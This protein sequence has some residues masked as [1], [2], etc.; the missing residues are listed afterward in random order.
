MDPACCFP[1]IGAYLRGGT[2]KQIH[3]TCWRGDLRSNT[4]DAAAGRKSH[5][6]T[7]FLHKGFDVLTGGLALVA[8]VLCHVKADTTCAD[9]GHPLTN[10]RLAS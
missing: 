4:L 1:Q 8:Q 10:D 7:P 3:L 6:Y 9:Y 2:L 5:V